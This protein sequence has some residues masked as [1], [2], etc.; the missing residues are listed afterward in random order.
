ML[1]RRRAGLLPILMV[2]AGLVAAGCARQA[3]AIET[4]D[5]VEAAAVLDTQAMT[6]TEAVTAL[7]TAAV[8]TFEASTVRVRMIDAGAE[9]RLQ[10]AWSPPDGATQRLTVTQRGSQTFILDDESVTGPMPSVSVEINLERRSGNR[11]RA[12]V[13][14]PVVEPNGAD[15]AVADY[16]RSVYGSVG[17]DVDVNV[18]AGGRLVGREPRLPSGDDGTLLAVGYQEQRLLSLADPLPSEPFGPGASW[19]TTRYVTVESFPV[20]IISRYKVTSLSGGAVK[21]TVDRSI[22]FSA[23]EYDE[24][25]ILDGSTLSG[26]GEAVWPKGAVVGSV[27]LELEGRIRYRLTFSRYL[28]QVISYSL[29]TANVVELPPTPTAT[30]AAAPETTDGGGQSQGEQAPAEGG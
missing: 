27:S 26:S 11:Y 16:A 29:D 19:E 8:P 25:E 6:A 4:A 21:A 10:R 30:T 22:R 2:A 20:T 14:E 5:A 18:E 12:R 3:N 15:P 23:G 24:T 1:P 17:G 13:S 9:P 7:P 28:D